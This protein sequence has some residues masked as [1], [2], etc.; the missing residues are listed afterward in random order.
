ML[1][2]A[3]WVFSSCLLAGVHCLLEFVN[4]SNGGTEGDLTNMDEYETGKVLDIMW[5]GWAQGRNPVSIIL[6]QADP[7]TGRKLE[8]END[9]MEYII[10]KCQWHSYDGAAV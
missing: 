7:Q 4:P 10:R 8:K 1:R 3:S 5:T 2:L 9:D 6:W